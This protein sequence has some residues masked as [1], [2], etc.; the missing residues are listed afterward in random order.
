MSNSL[1]FLSANTVGS[2]CVCVF[3]RVRQVEGVLM[4]L[5]DGGFTGSE[6]TSVCGVLMNAGMSCVDKIAV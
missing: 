1:W 2:V 3:G 5:P 4:C 6:F